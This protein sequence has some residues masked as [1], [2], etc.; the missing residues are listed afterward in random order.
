MPGAVAPPLHATGC[1]YGKLVCDFQ[2]FPVS[3]TGAMGLQGR[4]NTKTPH[5]MEV[6]N[7]WTAK[8]TIA[9]LVLLLHT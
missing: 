6:F 8:K 7:P 2:I 4:K 3:E 1:M 5:F 9:F